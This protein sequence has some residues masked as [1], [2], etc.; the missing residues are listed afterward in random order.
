MREEWM[1]GDL[2]T[3]VLGCYSHPFDKSWVGLRSCGNVSNWLRLFNVVATGWDLP[4]KHMS[5]SVK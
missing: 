3:S 5:A 1:E 2:E 4:Q